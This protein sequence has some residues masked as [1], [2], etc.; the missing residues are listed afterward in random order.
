MKSPFRKGVNVTT[1]NAAIMAA[2]SMVANYYRGVSPNGAK[3]VVNLA[4]D[5]VDEIEARSVETPAE[6]VQEAA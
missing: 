2:A 4:S 6:P 3:L 1:S 5:I